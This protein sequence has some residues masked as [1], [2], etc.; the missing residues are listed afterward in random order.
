M[1]L[2]TVLDILTYSGI[3]LL[4]GIALGMVIFKNNDTYACASSIHLRQAKD[5]IIK[6]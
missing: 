4:N 2:N 1:A 3:G 5:G 6:A